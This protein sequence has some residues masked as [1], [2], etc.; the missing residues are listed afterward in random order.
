MLDSVLF[1]V[2][3]CI[4]GGI[5]QTLKIFA[6]TLRWL[7]VHSS[8]SAS[9]KQAAAFQKINYGSMDEMHQVCI[10]SWIPASSSPL[11]FSLLPCCCIHPASASSIFMSNV[12]PGG[13]SKI[14]FISTS[15]DC[16]SS[17]IFVH[18][19]PDQR[20][21]VTEGDSS[22]RAT[23]ESTQGQ[24]TEQRIAGGHRVIHAEI[25]MRGRS[26]TLRDDADDTERFETA[27]CAVHLTVIWMT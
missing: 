6:E 22:I 4:G 23:Q 18:V 13:G 27:S 17:L 2:A 5:I 8:T 10:L 25:Y 3:F 20:A 7:T 1:V 19:R 24:D 11:L 12:E 16:R 15:R 26:R 9:K 14:E 21:S